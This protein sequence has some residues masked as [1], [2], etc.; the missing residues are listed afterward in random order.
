MDLKSKLGDAEAVSYYKS[1]KHNTSY[2]IV[3]IACGC[4]SV[5]LFGNIWIRCADW[6]S[7]G[8]LCVAFGT[9][10][11]NGTN[12][13]DPANSLAEK[14]AHESEILSRIAKGHVIDVLGFTLLF[15][16]LLF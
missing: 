10:Y 1:R 2:K 16:G 14:K 13:V 11:N 3:P 6:I 9:A 12:M 8:Q 5:G 7:L 4:L 15:L